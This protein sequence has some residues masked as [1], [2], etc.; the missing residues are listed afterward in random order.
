MSSAVRLTLCSLRRGSSVAWNFPVNG[1]VTVASL[2]Q[3]HHR[4]PEK[5]E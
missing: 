5:L 3:R 1:L 2:I 4:E